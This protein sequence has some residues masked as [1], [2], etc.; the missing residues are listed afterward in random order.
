MKDNQ[1]LKLQE[2]LDNAYETY[3]ALQTIVQSWQGKRASHWKGSLTPA[4]TLPLYSV[5]D[6]PQEAVRELFEELLGKTAGEMKTLNFSEMWNSFLAGEAG[7]PE[8]LSRLQMAIKGVIEVARL[9]LTKEKLSELKPLEQDVCPVCGDEVH[10]TLL[11]PPVGKRYLHCSTCGY[12][13]PVKRIGCI[14]CGSDDSSHLNYLKSE[15]YPGVEIVTCG[16]CGQTFKE[17]DLRESNTSDLVW[18]D[19]RTLPLDSA[20][21]QWLADKSL[22]MYPQDIMPS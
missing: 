17:I 15:E 7:E 2:T 3:T 13:W 8:Y 14:H 20:S 21:Q 9:S 6:L 5:T 12:E 18:E 19:I 22:G 1:T 10:L 16:G 11:V 4:P